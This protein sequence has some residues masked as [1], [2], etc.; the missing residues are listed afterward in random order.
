MADINSS[1]VG[2]EYNGVVDWVFNI[3]TEGAMNTAVTEVIHVPVANQSGN[4]LHD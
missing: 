2:T 4:Q 1:A 3:S